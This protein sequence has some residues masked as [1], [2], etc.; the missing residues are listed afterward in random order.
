MQD[1]QNIQKNRARETGMTHN[2]G[3]ILLDS[4]TQALC[5][6]RLAHFFH[7]AGVP[8]L[9]TLIRRFNIF[10]TGA[11]I[12]PSCNMGKGVRLIHSVG[13]V[14]AATTVV[15]DDCEIF[16]QVVLGG[17]GGS[18]TE[19]GAPRIGSNTVICIGAKILGPISV[20]KNVTVAAGAVV[21]ASVPGNCLVAGIPA[22][23]KTHFDGDTK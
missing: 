4:G 3:R 15:D 18:H 16:G 17:R 5:L 7:G 10:F 20:G 12:Y 22:T 1:H 19:D 2:L 13:I 9:P 8:L 14:I 23:I 11:D 6:H 21:L